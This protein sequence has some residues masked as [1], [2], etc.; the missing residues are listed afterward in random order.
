MR[1]ETT[2]FFSDGLALSGAFFT[3][4][5]DGP[6]IAGP[7]VIPCSG[8]TGLRDIHPARFARFLTARGHR[9][10]GFDYR[11]FADSEGPRGR[12]LLEEQVR[13]IVHAAAFVAGDERVDARRIVLLGWGMGAGLVLD[14]ARLV[15]GVVGVAAVNGFYNGDRVQRAHRDPDA[16][17]RFL[18]TVDEERT[19]RAQTGRAG[20]TDPFDIYPLDP[21]S[22]RYVDEVL[23]RAEGY[24]A[25]PYSY[26]L[27]D[28]LLRWNVEAHAPNMRIP[29]LV[30][31]GDKN[32]LHPVD[33]ATSLFEA[34]AGPKELFWLE[35]AGHTEFMHDDDP[36]FQALG[37]RIERWL[38]DAAL[39]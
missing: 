35:N 23:R 32:R 10:F 14:A 31:H 7:I 37:A 4:D 24:D 36:K 25:E 20:Q 2:T 1:T 5:D 39:A 26:E 6:N 29:L 8:F 22:R 28:S 30:A 21:Q 27:A 17:E 12:V 18:R 3:P 11:G 19:A 16:Y 13:D 33:A 38:T 34:W 9:C 15:R